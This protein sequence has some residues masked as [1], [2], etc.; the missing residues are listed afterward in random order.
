MHTIQELIDEGRRI[1]KVRNR[2]VQNS[3]YALWKNA[4]KQYLRNNQNNIKLS[5]SMTKIFDDIEVLKN[6]IE[7]NA[8]RK[9]KIFVV[10]GRNN[11]LRDA[12]FSFLRALNL[13]PM[14]WSQAI[15]LLES[16]S[17]F[18]GEVIDVALKISAAVIIIFSPDDLAVL[19][20]EF[21]KYDDKEEEKK[22]SPQPRPNVLF[23][24]GMAFGINP[25]K[26]IILQFGEL[27]QI[28]DIGGRHV[29]KMNNTPEKRKDLLDRLIN[30][31]CDLESGGTDWLKVGNF[32]SY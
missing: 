8:M 13:E 2:K 1:T 18:V 16:G 20:N 25:K 5:F 12:V 14:E 30:A 22:L 32:D 26:T 23:E 31:N 27:R 4:V 3:Q 29:I 9:K 21:V 6:S 28:S 15:A 11:T 17:P 10:H 7:K 24:A 19:K